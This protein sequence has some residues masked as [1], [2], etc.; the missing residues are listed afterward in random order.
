[1]ILSRP[2]PPALE[3]LSGERNRA[4]D[5]A[6]VEALPYLEPPVQ[7]A[8]LDLLIRRAHAPSLAGLV[9]RFR[10]LPQASREL[11]TSRLRQ[12]STGVR[13]AITSPNF[14]SR[15]NAVEAIRVSGEA[16]LAYLL[17]DAVRSRCRRTRPLAAEALQQM[18]ALLLDRRTAARDRKT[19]AEGNVQ[20]N[21]LTEA[22]AAAVHGWEIHYQPQVLE[23]ALWMGDRL[24]GVIRKKLQE[25]HSRIAKMLGDVV[26]GGSDPRMAGAVLRALAIPELRSAAVRAFTR[27]PN[28]AFFRAVVNASWVLTDAAVERGCRWIR[29]ERWLREWVE[30]SSRLSDGEVVGAVR[31]LEAAGC[32]HDRKM[33]AFRSF[34]RLDRPALAHAVVWRLIEDP[35]EAATDLLG[36]VA[37]RSETDAALIARR[38]WQRRRSPSPDATPGAEAA[39][40]SS[41]DFAGPDPFDRFFEDFERLSSEE[42][43]HTVAE[44]QAT[45]TYLPMRLR[46]KLASSSAFDRSQALRIVNAVGLLKEFDEQVYH[47]AHDP[48]A[49][50]RAVAVGLLAQLPGA[51]ATRIL[52]SAVD[53]ADGRV[54]A[55]A[56]ETLD[57]LHVEGRVESIQRKLDS[58]HARVRANAVKSLLRVELQ[59]AGH[60]LLDMLE[61]PSSAHR[62]SALWVIERLRLR[63][64]LHRILD[65]SRHDPDERVKRRA[66]RVLRHLNSE[67]DIHPR[68]PTSGVSATSG[69][70]MAGRA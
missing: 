13:L 32:A 38:E 65:L 39:P 14:E 52:R 25:P 45:P 5:A 64:V 49:T 24:D 22:L 68:R 43:A 17:A 1:M 36:M 51:T 30:G 46:A 11:I 6:L 29:D 50:V 47:L 63:A 35:S 19:I 31:L 66:Q 56:I 12:L 21:Y 10:N 4:A 70:P 53:D 8:S 48:D 15:A 26:Q 20:L 60:A 33:E 69:N 34:L 57:A 58:P 28:P 55:N 7:A 67:P 27:P 44:M 41:K 16:K 9:H 40:G 18:T 59:E 37:A 62:L 3:W 23:A 2:L 54:Q 42:R 61:N